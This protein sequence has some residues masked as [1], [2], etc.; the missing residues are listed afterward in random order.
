MK[1]KRCAISFAAVLT[2]LATV[3]LASAQSWLSDGPAPRSNHSGVLDTATNR[4]IIFGGAHGT[5]SINFGDSNDVWRL[6]NAG[7]G[8]L[9]WSY[10]SPSGTAPAKRVGSR[11]VYDPGSNRMII[12]GGGL[13]GSSPCVSD[14]WVLTNANGNGG[15]SAWAKLNPLGPAPAPRL[16]HTAVYDSASNTMTIF[17]GS[18]CFSTL[19]DDVWVLNNAN[20]VTGTPAWTQL[21]PSAA[22]PVPRETA[23]AVYDS[24]NKIMIVYG[25]TGYTGRLGDVWVLSNANGAGGTPTWTQLSP[26]GTLPTAR[27]NHSA[28]YDSANN[29]MTIFGG[30]D[31]ANNVLGDTWVLAGA[32]GIGGTPAWA[33][34][35]PFTTFADAR[36]GHIAVYNPSTNRMT[37]FGGT[38]ASTGQTTNDVFTLTN[39]NGLR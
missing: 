4:M 5:T 29:R 10:V 30:S 12:F 25:G 21:A 14:V 24:S 17:G 39:A 18:D 8:G 23:T 36:L 26:S 6:N 16:F 33:Q 20:G 7:S 1:T 3:G 31:A 32:N 38:V 34:L 22:L 13:G 27:Q 11:A 37:V 35:G 2:A 28:V 19:F 9:T 15:A